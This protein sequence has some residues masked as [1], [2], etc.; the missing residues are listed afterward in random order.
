MKISAQQLRNLVETTI[1]ESEG[2][3]ATERRG[4]GGEEQYIQALHDAR[5]ALERLE[6]AAMAA[7]GEDDPLRDEISTAY[8]I[9]DTLI[10]D[11]Q[12]GF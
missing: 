12:G 10:Y 1:H 4:I 11:T 5:D 3:I 9:I 8:N 6:N 7:F 2:D